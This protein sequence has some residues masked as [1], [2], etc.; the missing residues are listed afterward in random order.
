[1]EKQKL[2]VKVFGEKSPRKFAKS[3]HSYPVPVLH[4]QIYESVM[5]NRLLTDGQIIHGSLKIPSQWEDAGC[6]VMLTAGL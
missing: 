5:L 1:M 2:S 4:A 3:W 6:S